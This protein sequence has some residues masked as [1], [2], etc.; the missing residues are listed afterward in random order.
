MAE[1]LL[2][3]SDLK[4]FLSMV[5]TQE[6]SSGPGFLSEFL[7]LAHQEWLNFFSLLILTYSVL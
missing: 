3:V 5:A 7:L 1:S 4:T 2:L 6:P